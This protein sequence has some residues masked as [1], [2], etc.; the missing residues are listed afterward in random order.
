MT[1]GDDQVMNKIKP[2]GT[3]TPSCPTFLDKVVQSLF[4]QHRERRPDTGLT[5]DIGAAEPTAVTECEV[6]ITAKMIAI[7]KAPG[8]DGVPGLAIKT[9]VLNVSYIF[10]ETFNAC[11]SEEIFPAQWKIQRLVLL[12]KGNKPP[13]EPS[14]YRPLCMLD[15][16]GKLFERIIS[17][18][19][20]AAIQQVGGLS[21]K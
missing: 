10:E 6:K 7:R 11:L 1:R 17:V 16:A 13:D 14:A 9:A 3:S 4:P 5:E 18:R 8:L 2:R 15:I 20:E 19:L 12:P 21:D